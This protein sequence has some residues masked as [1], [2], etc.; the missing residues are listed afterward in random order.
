MRLAWRQLPDELFSHLPF[1][2]FSTVGGMALVAILTFIG[3]PFYKEG[4]GDAFHEL[5]HIFHPIHMLFSATA[6]T[7][8]FWRYERH[9][10]KASIVGLL[11]AVLVCGASDILIPYVSGFLLGAPM[12]L[13]ICVIEHPALVLPF[14]VVGVVTGILS[15]DYITRATFFSHSAHV[16]VSSAASLLYMVSYG[17]E[18]WVHDAGWVFIFVVLAVMIPCCFSDIVFPLLVVTKDGAPPP[19]GHHHH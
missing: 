4:L 18:H 16:L 5:F 7:A 14:A 17:L 10:L 12:H 8:M 6:T 2:I 19:C 13:H 15:A 1:S 9:W 11:G 3:E